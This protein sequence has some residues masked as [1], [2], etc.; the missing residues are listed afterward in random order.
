VFGAVFACI[1]TSGWTHTQWL[2]RYDSNTLHC[3]LC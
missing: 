3:P 2:C 1:M